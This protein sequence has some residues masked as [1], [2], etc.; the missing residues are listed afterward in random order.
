MHRFLRSLP[1]ALFLLLN[2]VAPAHAGPM[3]AQLESGPT[4]VLGYG[5]AIG[6]A[7]LVLL[8]VCWPARRQ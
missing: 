2:A 1:F 3:F 4:N 5:I 7:A 6:A 8:V